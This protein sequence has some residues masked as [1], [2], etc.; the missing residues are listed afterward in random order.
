MRRFPGSLARVMRRRPADPPGVPSG[1]EEV[2]VAPRVADRP[3]TEPGADERDADEMSRLE[4]EALHHRNR[5]ALDRARVLTARPAS[6]ARLR[7]LQRASDGA[8]VRLRQARQR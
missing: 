6:A 1:R 2:P 8:E 5:L 7:E 4:A 3:P